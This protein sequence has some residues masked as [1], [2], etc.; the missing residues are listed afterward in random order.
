M[1]RI[2]IGQIHVIWSRTDKVHDNGHR[3]TTSLDFPEIKF[4]NAKFSVRMETPDTATV[5]VPIPI[6]V[7]VMNN[8]TEMQPLRIALAKCPN[9][10]I[11][12]SVSCVPYI[13]SYNDALIGVL[14]CGEYAEPRTCVHAH[15]KVIP[16]TAGPRLLPQLEVTT[17]RDG[18]ALVSG[19]CNKEIFVVP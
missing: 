14:T 8:T 9:F 6:T 7:F 12:G 11:D 17:L 1:H 15:F 18:S 4:R 3:A 10:M 2:A 5:G 13:V 19:G 16:T